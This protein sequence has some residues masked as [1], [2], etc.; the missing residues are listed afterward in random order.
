MLLMNYFDED[1]EFIYQQ[2]TNVHRSSLKQMN[3]EATGLYVELST[4]QKFSLQKVIDSGAGFE[5]VLQSIED[6]GISSKLGRL[7]KFDLN[8]LEREIDEELWNPIRVLQGRTTLVKIQGALYFVPNKIN[9]LGEFIFPLDSS[10]AKKVVRSEINQRKKNYLLRKVSQRL[11]AS[12][13]LL[14]NFGKCYSELVFCLPENISDH[15]SEMIVTPL[16]DAP[17][18]YLREYDLGILEKSVY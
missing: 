9:A 6:F 1:Q 18:D 15:L 2:L 10:V 8:E 5:D 11:S 4:Q 3:Y 7:R 14:L 13:P 16:G 12:H 17:K